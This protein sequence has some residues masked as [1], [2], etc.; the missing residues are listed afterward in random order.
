MSEENR[1]EKQE[2]EQEYEQKCEQ[3]EPEDEIK[4]DFKT[5]VSSLSANALYHMGIM[6]TPG[7]Q[8]IEV[9]LSLARYTIDIIDMLKEKS[10]G[11][12]TEDEQR[13]IDTI[14]YDLKLKFVDSCKQDSNS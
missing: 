4:P 10:L 3:E 13:F 8:Q 9:N 14:L 5:F 7:E 1:E 6:K 2:V 11:N 12:L